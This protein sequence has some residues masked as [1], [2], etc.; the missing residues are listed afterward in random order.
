MKCLL[1]ILS[2]F[3]VTMGIISI[4]IFFFCMPSYLEEY[5]SLESFVISMKLVKAG[6]GLTD[7]LGLFGSFRKKI[8]IKIPR[9]N[10]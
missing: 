7:T 4:R 6:V 9:Y 3:G 5:I 8:F 2:V 10:R 1:S